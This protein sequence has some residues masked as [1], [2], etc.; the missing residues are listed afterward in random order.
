MATSTYSKLS[1]QNYCWKWEKSVVNKKKF[2]MCYLEAC[3]YDGVNLPDKANTVL[4]HKYHCTVNKRNLD[5]ST[6]TCFYFLNYSPLSEVYIL[7]GLE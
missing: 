1:C 7:R 4:M 5:L 6:L 3:K 2:N